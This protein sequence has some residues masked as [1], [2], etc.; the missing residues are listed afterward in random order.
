MS[1]MMPKTTHSTLQIWNTNIC[2][3]TYHLFLS[4]QAP[5]HIITLLSLHTHCIC[6]W[7]G[8]ASC[9]RSTVPVWEWS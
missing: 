6:D 8:W 4:T 3:S 5:Y 9:S 2:P 7:D 1:Y